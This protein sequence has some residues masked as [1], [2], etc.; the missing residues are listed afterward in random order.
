MLGKLTL[1]GRLVKRLAATEARPGAA[2]ATLPPG[3]DD[4]PPMRPLRP[5]QA[6]NDDVMQPVYEAVERALRANGL[7]R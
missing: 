1:P 5:P 6:Q 4:F 2:V 3:A 7:L